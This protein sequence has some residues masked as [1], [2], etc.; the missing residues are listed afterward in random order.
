MGTC[1]DD[2]QNTGT[3]VDFAIGGYTGCIQIIDKGVN[4]PFKTYACEEFENWMFSNI[5]P[6]HP[7]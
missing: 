3:E 4:R 5:S 6:R 7:T 1:L 2:I